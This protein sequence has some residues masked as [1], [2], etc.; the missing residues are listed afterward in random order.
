[1]S[2]IVIWQHLG[3]EFMVEI[4]KALLF[5]KIFEFVLFLL[6]G[7]VNSTRPIFM[8]P[9]RHFIVQIKS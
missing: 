1:M 7:F 4:M 2:N 6:I 8:D 5:T 9:K 3:P